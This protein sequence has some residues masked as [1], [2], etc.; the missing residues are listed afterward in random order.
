M[1]IYRIKSE[2]IEGKTYRVWHFDN[3]LYKCDCPDFVLRRR[4]QDCKHI[5]KVK[6]QRLIEQVKEKQEQ[7]IQ[8]QPYMETGEELKQKMLDLGKRYGK[9]YKK[10]VGLIRWRD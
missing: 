5:A 6:E 8:N 1:Q 10:K 3:G 2:T 7:K 4:G 9:Q